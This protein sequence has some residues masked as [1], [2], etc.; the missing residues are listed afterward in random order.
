M[1]RAAAATIILSLMF[2][3]CTTPTLGP[4][5]T[6]TESVMWPASATGLLMKIGALAF[7]FRRRNCRGALKSASF[8]FLSGNDMI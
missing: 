2:T 1:R 4:P 6:P 8:P 3:G 5:A 7:S